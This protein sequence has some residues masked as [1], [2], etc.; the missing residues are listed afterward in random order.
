MEILPI[1][2]EQNIEFLNSQNIWFVLSENPKAISCPDA[3]SKRNRLGNKGIPIFDELKSELGFFTNKNGDEQKILVH[4]RGNQKIDRLK[5]SGILNAEYQRLE[6]DTH[7]KGLINPF[8][9]EFRNLLQVFDISTIKKFHPPFTMMTN[10]GDFNYAIEFETSELIKILKNALVEDIIRI[11][12]YNNFVKHKIGILTGNGPD[13]GI[14][15][16]KKIN[17][18]VKNILLNKSKS[19]FK[20]DLSFPEIVIESIPEMGISMDLG[21]RLKATEK[22]VIKSII[23]LCKNGS[24]LICIACNTTQYFKSE[25][26]YV[27]SLYNVE[28]VSIPDVLESYLVEKGILNFDF[29]GISYVVDFDKYSAFKNL[30]KKFSISIPENSI[31]EKINEIAFNAKKDPQNNSTAQPLGTILREKTKNDTIVVAL[32]EI[33]TVLDFHKKLV[34][35]KQVIDTLQVLADAIAKKYIEGIFQT[36]FIDEAKDL[37]TYQKLDNDI[38]KEIQN[39]IW[40]ILVEIDYEF[41]PP[42]SY[43]DSTT[44]SFENETKDVFLPKPYFDNLLKQTIIVSKSRLNDNVIGFMSYIPDHIITQNE[45]NISCHYITTIGVTKGSRG[46]GITVQFYSEIEKIVRTSS[47]NKVIAT[48]TWSTNRTHIRVL[49]SLGYKKIIELRDDRGSGIH[50]VYYSKQIN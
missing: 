17:D 21:N 22:T 30:P 19:S 47:L 45:A 5:I 31:L 46:N 27:C 11:D 7:T 16:W 43:R 2:V 3:A 35:S 12:N 32:T 15:L 14:L 10:A 40:K 44:F 24:T 9:E 36:L 6:S 34:Q 4:C 48:R 38:H 49:E 29:I 37:I 13:S 25:I 18:S 28:F 33:S 1:E 20:G 41:I 26:E 50:T 39:Q 8:G 23:D 42:L